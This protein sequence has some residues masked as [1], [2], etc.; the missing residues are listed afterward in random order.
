M[1]PA[2]W[3]GSTPCCM[4]QETH[5]TGIGQERIEVRAGSDTVREHL[6]RTSVWVES[7]RH[8][9]PAAVVLELDGFGWHGDRAGVPGSS[10]APLR[11]DRPEQDRDGVGLVVVGRAKPR[12]RTAAMTAALSALPL[13]VMKRL[14]VPTGTPW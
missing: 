14:I 3:L 8:R 10:H 4:R 9:E 1:L 5:D 12:A 11:L 6:S 2:I 7:D 13:P